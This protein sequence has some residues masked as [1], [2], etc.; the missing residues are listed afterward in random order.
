MLPPKVLLVRPACFSSNAEAMRTNS[1]MRP[2]S[3]PPVELAQAAIEE[4]DAF[5]EALCAAGI[6]PIVFQDTPDP[7]KPDAV[8]PNNW[9][10]THTDAHGRGIV[11]FYPMA[12]PAR[13][14]ERRV[15]ILG[16][17]RDEGRRVDETIDLSPNETQGRYLEGTGA[18]VLCRETKTAFL[19][20]SPRGHECVAQEWADRMG[21]SL[22]SFDASDAT[23][24][25]VYHANVLMTLAPELAAC[26]LARIAEADR[27]RV[28]QAI[29]ETGRQLLELT[30]EQMDHFCGNALAV[31]AP[32]GPAWACS[33]QAW[34]AYSPQQRATIERRFRPIT[35]PIPLIERVGGGSV[36]CMLAEIDLP[37]R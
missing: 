9:F 36:R 32:G 20:R 13:R 7:P 8:F 27:A 19:A 22:V 17:L 30:P 29:G 28:A 5:A 37:A 6:E 1:Y 12:T 18:L 23:G 26:C 10:S 24:G 25:A 35:A 4:F 14:P 3:G 2:A 33:E 31:A 34:S 21:Y 16:L 15:E 11:V